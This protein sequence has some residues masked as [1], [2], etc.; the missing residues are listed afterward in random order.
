MAGNRAF[1]QQ[2]A[3]NGNK[4]LLVDTGNLNSGLYILEVKSDENIYRTKL[5][6][7]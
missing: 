6:V 3:F 5:M 4:N 7:R 2:F 1:S